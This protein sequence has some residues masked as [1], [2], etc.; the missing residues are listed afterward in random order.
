MWEYAREYRNIFAQRLQMIYC[1]EQI[2]EC[3]FFFSKA[4]WSAFWSVLL[5]RLTSPADAYKD[6]VT[7][8]RE[9]PDY[10]PWVIDASMS[11]GRCEDEG[12][13]PVVFVFSVRLHEKID[14][15]PRNPVG[16]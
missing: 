1:Y 13:K 8:Y 5:T 2:V 3:F 6:Y 11:A 16:R 15:Q 10:V 14:L 7:T 4:F 12:P 9:P